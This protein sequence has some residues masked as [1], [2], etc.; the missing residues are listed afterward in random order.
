MAEHVS[1]T[2]DLAFHKV[3]ASVGNEDI[4][5]GLIQD[6]FEIRP[7]LGA[8]TITTPYSIQSYRERLARQSADD[9][10]DT[11]ETGRLRMTVQDVSADIEFAGFGAE[12]Q[13]RQ[14]PHFDVRSLKYTFDN[15]SR[16]YH[17][18]GKMARRP[19]GSEIYYSSL[20]PIYALNIMKYAHFDEDD[21]ALRVFT[22][23]D[24][25][26]RKTFRREYVTIGY[27]ELCKRN[28]ETESQR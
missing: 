15:F 20:K 26:R 1:P 12:M 14:N 11:G 19:D 4:L 24:R 16:N 21:D 27:F 23:Y 8:I 22:L 25:K 9:T 18:P 10:D 6:F 7:E 3:F 28:V 5:Q 17:V 2:N 13:V